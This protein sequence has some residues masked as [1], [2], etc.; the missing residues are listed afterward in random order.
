MSYCIVHCTAKNKKEAL[1][2][3]EVLVEKRLIACCNIISS[4]TSVYEWDGVLHEDK[5]V[6]MIMKTETEM[7]KQIEN[8]IKKVHSYNMPELICIPIINGSRK[9]L[10]WV[11]YQVK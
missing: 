7:F 1:E 5:E 2:I 9:Y 10:D 4:V 6:L 11:D 3:A 8:I